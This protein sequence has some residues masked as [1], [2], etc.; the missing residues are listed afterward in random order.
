MVYN[1]SAQATINSVSRRHFPSI[2]AAALRKK[3]WL[4]RGEQPI[5]QQCGGGVGGV[6]HGTGRGDLPRDVGE[7]R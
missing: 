2:L 7:D 1:L 6:G 4:C 5:A 3:P